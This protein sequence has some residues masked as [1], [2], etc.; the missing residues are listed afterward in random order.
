[1]QVMSVTSYTSPGIDQIPVELNQA[2]GKTLRYEIRTLINSIY[3]K[4]ELHQRW[5]ESITV[6]IY[7][8]DDKTAVVIIRAYHYYQLYTNFYP[9]SFSQG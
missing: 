2:G 7:K 4:E 3:N 9:I 1:M 8:K 5:K 6:P